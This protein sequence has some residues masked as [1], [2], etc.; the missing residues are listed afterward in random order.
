[1][2]GEP[3]RASERKAGDPVQTV[4]HD[5]SAA[6]G[7]QRSWGPFCTR[8]ALVFVLTIATSAQSDY[9]VAASRSPRAPK[10]GI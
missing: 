8:T 5:A 1:M 2:D 3:S 7:V 4:G 6:G 10:V 9:D